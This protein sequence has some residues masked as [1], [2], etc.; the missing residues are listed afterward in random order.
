MMDF[1]NVQGKIL[2][3]RQMLWWHPSQNNTGTKKQKKEIP[4]R[5]KLDGSALGDLAIARNTIA[6]L[7]LSFW[8]PP[9]VTNRPLRLISFG[10]QS[11]LIKTVANTV[12][13]TRHKAVA[14]ARYLKYTW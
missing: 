12:E 10:F 3:A 8:P 7:P 5:H 9:C 11:L 2:V 14:L 1:S 6:G 4:E 13:M